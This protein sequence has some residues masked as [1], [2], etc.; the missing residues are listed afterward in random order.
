MLKCFK[1]NKHIFVVIF[2]KN[3]RFLWVEKKITYGPFSRRDQQALPE[4]QLKPQ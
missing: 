3:L 4:H 1:Q 2:K